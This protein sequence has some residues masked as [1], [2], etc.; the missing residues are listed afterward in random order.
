MDR[1]SSSLMPRSWKKYRKQVFSRILSF[2][3]DLS[4]STS[5]TLT[6]SGNIFGYCSATLNREMSLLSQVLFIDCM[7]NFELSSAL[8]IFQAYLIDFL[9]PELSSS[10]LNEFKSRRFQPSGFFYCFVA[11]ALASWLPSKNCFSVRFLLMSVIFC[12]LCAFLFAL[13]TLSYFNEF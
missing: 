11:A 10:S 6:T 8:I 5:R 4:L 13:I 9:A 3:S 7:A 12:C 1:F 2:S